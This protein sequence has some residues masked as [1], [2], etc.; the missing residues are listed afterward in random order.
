M[1]GPLET[2]CPSMEG[3]CS[4]GAGVGESVEEHPYGGKGEWGEGECDGGGCV[5]VTGK[6]DIILNVNK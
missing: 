3:C 2:W 6:G 5:G 4:S 1:L